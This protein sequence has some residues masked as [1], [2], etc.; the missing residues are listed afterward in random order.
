MPFKV[1]VLGV[2]LRMTAKEEEKEE[3]ENGRR[4]DKRRRRRGRGGGV[5]GKGGKMFKHFCDKNFYS[6]SLV[7]DR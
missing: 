2:Q 7:L 3:Q 1:L 4:R 5:E 6:L